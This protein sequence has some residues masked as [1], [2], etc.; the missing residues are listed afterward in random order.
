MAFIAYYFHWSHEEPLQ[1]P[2]LFDAVGQPGD[3]LLVGL[4]PLVVR[5][6]VEVVEG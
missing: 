2:V 6:G 4:R 1:D 3:G 5:V